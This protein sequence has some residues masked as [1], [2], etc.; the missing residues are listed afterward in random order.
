MATKK[1][2]SSAER[3]LKKFNEINK[4]QQKVPTAEQKADTQVFLGSFVTSTG[5]VPETSNE[6]FKLL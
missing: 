6:S 3:F 5:Q 2:Y 4:I 1:Q